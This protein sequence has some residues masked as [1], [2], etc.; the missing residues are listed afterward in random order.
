MPDNLMDLALD[1]RR[2]Q[3]VPPSTAWRR[4]IGL[5]NLAARHTILEDDSTPFWPE[6]S[7]ACGRGRDGGKG[8]GDRVTTCHRP[9]CGWGFL[10]CNAFVRVLRGKQIAS[11][12]DG[13]GRRQRLFD[14]A[15][16]RRLRWKILSL[17]LDMKKFILLS[18]YI[19]F[20]IPELKCSF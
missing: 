18:L 5:T 8:E 11:H 12:K 9:A 15:A 10:L 14:S 6:T 19:F 7:L 3:F 2:A 17:L 1:G 16:S 13:E 4:P 20:G